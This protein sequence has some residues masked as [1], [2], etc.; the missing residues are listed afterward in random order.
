LTRLARTAAAFKLGVD[1][2]VFNHDFAELRQYSKD[3]ASLALVLSGQNF[4][5]VAFADFHLVL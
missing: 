5:G 4:D 3:F 1:V 2:Y